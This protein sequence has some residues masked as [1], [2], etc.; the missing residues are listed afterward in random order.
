VL[1]DGRVQAFFGKMDMGQGL[2]IAVAQIVADELDVGFDK[3]EVVMGD[4]ASSCN[5]GG[6]SGSTGVSNGARLLRS[7]AA[8]ARRVLVERA[9]KQLDVPVSQLSV[10]DGLISSPTKKVSYAELVGGRYFHHQVEWNK[11]TGNPMDIKVPAKPKAPADYKVVGKPL[12]RRDI[13]WKV[14]GTDDYVTDVRVPGMLHARVIRPP[15]AACKVRSVDE[16]SIKSIKGVRVVRE[17]DFVA[18]VA[19][20]EWDAVRAAQMLK[21]DWHA[22]DGAFPG[23]DKLYDHIRAAKVVKREDAVKRG[24]VAAAFAK[25]PKL[26]EAQYEW[27]MQSHASM[28]PACALADVKQGRCTVWTGSQKPHFVQT[29]VARLLGLTPDKVHA[30]WVSGP[31]S[32]GR[33]DAGDAA[34]DA[35]FLSRATGKPVRVQGMRSD[36]T[37]WDPKGPACVHRARAALDA[38]GKVVAYEF[39]AKGFSR[40]HIATNESDPADSLIGQSTGIPPKGTQIFGTPAESYGFDS[41]LLAWETIPPFVDSCSPLRTG[42]LRD[43]VG[44][45]IHFGSEQFIDELALAA[46]EDPVA[47]RLKYLTN[48][49]H[50]AVV[51]AVAEKSKWSAL[52]KGKGVAFAERN[53]TAVAVVAQVEVDRTSG[54]IWAKNFWVAHDCGLVINPL[55]LK[56]TI[57]GN[58]VH[59]LSR[60]LFEEVRFD[61]DSVQS[62]DWASYPI[63]EMQDAPASIDV[64]LIDRP[65]IASTGAGEPTIRV[66]PGAV[67][68]AFYDAT[69]VRMRTA[70]LAPERVKAALSQ[71]T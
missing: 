34:L 2:D 4:T 25:A 6:A 32:Y 47:F 8:E 3:V 52:G 11:Q 33:N 36:G 48:P 20:R 65:E 10:H 42:H 37:A 67:A 35:A 5:Q 51:K 13:A 63:L 68:N 69:G 62:V 58:V 55:Q 1:P 31:G 18:V 23:M 50:Q 61:R 57:E 22:L 70:P 46:G 16:G 12:P 44:P 49:R 64:T 53:G 21:I 43:P 28:G 38:S 29:G 26:V 56:Q 39:V 59:G 45:E 14:Y 71:K 54:R 17:K 60:T 30:I 7:A 9:S 15:R 19:A 41:K 66:I 40:Q 24:D 27:P